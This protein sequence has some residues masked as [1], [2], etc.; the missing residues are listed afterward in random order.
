MINLKNRT[1]GAYAVGTSGKLER[2]N[3][4]PRLPDNAL[5]LIVLRPL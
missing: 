5:G 4:S 2:L 1:S 3:A